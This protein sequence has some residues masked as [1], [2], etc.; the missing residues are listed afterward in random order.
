MLK[1]AM[2]LFRERGDLIVLFFS[3]KRL[4]V[5]QFSVGSNRATSV[6]SRASLQSAAAPIAEQQKQTS[7]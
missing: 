7:W 5:G 4:E 2:T 1:V 3:T 6:D